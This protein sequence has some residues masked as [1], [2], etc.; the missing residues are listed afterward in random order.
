M[1]L[2]SKIHYTLDVDTP[3]L[4]LILQALGGRIIT[5]EQQEQARALGNKLTAMRANALRALGE[6]AD[7]LDVALGQ[8]KDTP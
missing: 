4:R 5:P 6:T 1:Q 7:Q 8:A 3:E 2:L